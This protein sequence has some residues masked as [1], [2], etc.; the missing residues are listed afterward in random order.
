MLGASTNEIICNKIKEK[1]LKYTSKYTLAVINTVYKEGEISYKESAEQVTYYN[2]NIED[3]KKI[4][5]EVQP[6]YNWM[7]ISY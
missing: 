4:V 2:T 7:H 1:S 6:A 5:T 3:I